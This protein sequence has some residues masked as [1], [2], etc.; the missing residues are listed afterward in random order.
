MTLTPVVLT[1]AP[2]SSFR[3]KCNITKKIKKLSKHT[4]DHDLRQRSHPIFIESNLFLFHVN[5]AINEDDILMS[6][7]VDVSNLI[8]IYFYFIDFL[9]HTHTMLY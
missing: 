9:S 5:K 6:Q 4:V 7:L 1:I 8:I 3:R 2:F